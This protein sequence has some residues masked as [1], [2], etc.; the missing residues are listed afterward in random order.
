MTESGVAI[1]KNYFVLKTIH[2]FLRSQMRTDEKEQRRLQS[3]SQLEQ[4]QQVFQTA[5]NTRTPL[6]TPL[7][8]PEQVDIFF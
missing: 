2:Y 7:C 8:A 3:E 6:Y 1:L 5:E 4:L